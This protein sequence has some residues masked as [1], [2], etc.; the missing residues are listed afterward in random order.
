L[1]I[2]ILHFSFFKECLECEKLQQEIQ[3]N[4]QQFNILLNKLNKKS[5][6]DL[7]SSYDQV[8]ML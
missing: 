7:S 2:F 4:E 6:A 5:S 8:R 1:I 3:R